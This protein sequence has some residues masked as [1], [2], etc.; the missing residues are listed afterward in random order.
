MKILHIGLTKTV[1]YHIVYNTA[2]LDFGNF[3]KNPPAK[4]KIFECN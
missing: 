2:A 3:G 1:D 4:F